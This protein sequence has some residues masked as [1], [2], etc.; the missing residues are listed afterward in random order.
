MQRTDLPRCRPSSAAARPRAACGRPAP[1]RRC[2][3]PPPPTAPSGST[4]KCRALVRSRAARTQVALRLP[5]CCSVCGLPPLNLVETCACLPCPRPRGP[6]GPPPLGAGEYTAERLK[7]LQ[8]GVRSLP[9]SGQPPQAA[10]AFKLAGSFKASAPPKDDRYQ[11]N[12]SAAGVVAAAQLQQRPAA[13]APLGDMPLP[14]PE[15]PPPPPP[16]PPPPAAGQQQQQEVEEDEEP[17]IPDEDMIAWAKAKRERLRG[18]H[19]APDYI[20]AAAGP[21]GLSLGRLRGAQRGGGGEDTSVVAS[22]AAAEHS[23]SEEEVEEHMRM[24]FIG[25]GG[26]KAAGSGGGIGGPAA[27]PVRGGRRRGGGAAAEPDEAEEDERWAQEQI[28]KGMGGLLAP[29]SSSL[30]GSGA[31]AAAG[32][33][34]QL[35]VG[36]GAGGRGGGASASGLAAGGGS[37]AAAIQAA[38]D[39]VLRTLQGGLLRLQMSRKQAEQN[40]QRTSGNLQVCVRAWGTLQ[41]ARTMSSPR[42]LGSALP[43]TA[44]AATA[45]GLPAGLPC[46]DRANAGRPGRRRRQVRLHPE[47]AG[48]RGGPLQHAAGGVEAKR[49]RRRGVVCVALEGRGSCCAGPEAA[50]LSADMSLRQTIA[51][52]LPARSPTCCCAPCCCAP[53]RRTS[54]RWWRSWRRR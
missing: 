26:G 10:A 51:P 6:S 44:A 50:G 15:E 37:Q 3:L 48:V 12:V 32:R 46:L 4:L 47:A 30:L 34:R 25:G 27:A 38:A 53:H 43:T 7:E 49:W 54:R 42:R 1:R 14:P 21:P 16:P 45:P 18:A 40:L 23:G 31:L 20:P 5:C 24:K 11:H 41:H 2:R 17:D 22:A 36:G 9:S 52:A 33:G 13:A 28:R 35:D 39:E 8:Q 29:G 19:L